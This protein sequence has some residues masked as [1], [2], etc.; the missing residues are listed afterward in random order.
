MTPDD[1]LNFELRRYGHDDVL[2][3][4][5]E[6]ETLEARLKDRERSMEEMLM[7][8]ME[9]RELAVEYALNAGYDQGRK[10]GQVDGR[11]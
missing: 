7:R 8:A 4:V 9:E 1:K 11:A 6:Y 3:L 5:E 2:R 10:D